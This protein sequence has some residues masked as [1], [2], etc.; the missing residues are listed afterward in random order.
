[1]FSLKLQNLLIQNFNL[2][3]FN[4]SLNFNEQQPHIYN[5]TI[6]SRVLHTRFW[7]FTFYLFFKLYSPET[8]LKIWAAES[9]NFNDLMFSTQ[10]CL[11]IL[12]LLFF[13]IVIWLSQVFFIK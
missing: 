5:H 2:N 11:L 7:T 13:I 12:L 10:L 6:F 8:I 4:K 1:M 3:Q 9:Y